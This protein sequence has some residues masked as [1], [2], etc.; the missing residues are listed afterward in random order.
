MFKTYLRKTI[1]IIIYSI[2]SIPAEG[3]KRNRVSMTRYKHPVL[4]RHAIALHFPTHL[5]LTVTNFFWSVR[6]RWKWPVSLV[7]DSLKSCGVGHILLSL[8]LL[9]KHVSRWSLHWFE[10]LWVSEPAHND[11]VEWVKH[12]LDLKQQKF[13]FGYSS[14]PRIF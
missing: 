4:C 5:N 7:G 13:G 10:F 2:A 3:N 11:L 14:I 12:N 6:W 9:Q 8:P 1:K